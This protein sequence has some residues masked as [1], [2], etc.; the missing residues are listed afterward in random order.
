MMPSSSAPA[1]PQTPAAPPP[2]PMFG[3]G[4]GKK[5]PKG[6]SQQPSFLG[7]DA[8]ANPANT[9]TKTLLGA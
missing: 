7:Q 4:Q 8:A 2:P 6:Q 5:K 3:M 1:L 9:G